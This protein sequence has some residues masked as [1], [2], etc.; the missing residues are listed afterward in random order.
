MA[1]V[2]LADLKAH[3]GISGTAEEVALTNAINAANGA[4][5]RRCRRSFDDAET[6]SA[7]VFYPTSPVVVFVDDFHTTDGLI[8]KTDTTDDGTF[9]TT[10]DAA[11]YQVEP[12][13]GIVDGE[14]V[15]YSRLRAVK[16]R[17]FPC[18]DRA[19]VEATAR[20]GWAGPPGPVFEAALLIA[21]RLFKRKDSPH[22][23]VGF[24]EFALRMSR[25]DPDVVGLLGPYVK[26]PVL[27]G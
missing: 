15:P 12:L 17:T 13:N 3:L 16:S 6:V 5:V 9:D 22:G 26:E 14:T 27:L 11:D 2:D 4:V 7:R 24:D 23:S 18:G 21:G 25:E 10:W 19:G 20:W 1:I 8:V